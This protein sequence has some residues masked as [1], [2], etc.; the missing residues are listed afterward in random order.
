MVKASELDW[1]PM[2]AYFW[3]FAGLLVG[4]P[5]IRARSRPVAEDR[6]TS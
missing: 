1:D 4:L 5:R 6:T 2:D 3:L